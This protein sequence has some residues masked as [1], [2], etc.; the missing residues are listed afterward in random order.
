MLISSKSALADQVYPV[1][2]DPKNYCDKEKLVD[3]FHNPQISIVDQIESQV[4]DLIKSSHPTKALSKKELDR[5]IEEFFEGQIKEDYGNW[6]YYPWKYTLVHLLPE[7]EFIKV[8]TLRNNYKITPQE[9]AELAQKKVGIVGLSVGQSIALVMSLERSFG[10]LRLAD[11]DTLELS[12]LNRL[13]AG[14]TNLG[15]EKVVIAAR[16]ISEMDPYLK[17][18]LYRGG[19]SEDN[20]DEFFE[21]G[22]MLDLIIDECDSLDIKVLLREKARSKKVALMME[23]SDRG[24]LD[25]ERFDDEPDRPLFHGYLGD[26][27]LK[28]LK[29]L[30]NKQKVPM[31]LKITGE[32]TLSTRMKAS[33]LEVTQSITSWPQL[34][35]S[36]FLGGASIGH[37]A[38]NFLLGEDIESG[39]YFV[40]L[41]ELIPSKKIKKV[42]QT[43]SEGLSQS[44]SDESIYDY[45]EGS[46]YKLLPE[47]LEHLVRLANL[48]PSGGNS[49]PWKWVFDK[50]GV[51]HLFEDK[52]LS[53]SLLDYKSSGSLLAFGAALENIRLA[54]A[55][56]GIQVEIEYKISE[57][58]QDYIAQVRFLSKSSESIS[59]PFGELSQGISLRCTNRKNGPKEE[60][61]SEVLEILKTIGTK[62]KEISIEVVSSN[63]DL[64]QLAGIIG[65][66]DRY[67]LLHEQGYQDFMNEIRWSDEEAKSTGDGI[68]I[69][70]LEMD[71]SSRA[72]MGLVRDPGTVEFFRKHDLGF[73]LSKISDDTIL[74][75]SAILMIESDSYDPISILKAGATLQRIWLKANILGISIQPVS[76]SL[77]IFHRVECE[78]NS[79]FSPEEKEGIKGLKKGLNEIFNKDLK[80][81]EIF[82]IRL[83][84]ADEPSMRSY[85]RDVWTSLIVL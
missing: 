27:N 83:N 2:L 78:E 45:K 62:E 68:D 44:W 59:V 34:A 18:K 1:I 29:N 42:E 22:G 13:R 17:L 79:G 19:I 57:F 30:T 11:F 5:L 31:V 4:A 70:T 63:E 43:P 47:E 26:L 50:N 8:R 75:S 80:K 32:D 55:D 82:M 14:V 46:T 72:A 33:L 20:I 40:D 69:A 38:R 12:N 37:V 54:S 7:E 77:F 61:K 64:K 76:A 67:R 81:K 71:P 24:M 16:E 15:T 66:M 10:E 25:V 9:Q 28:S 51:L 60:L 84:K 53:N 35:S 21:D 39:R 85:R 52:S 6:V 3:L 23:T 74:S 41:D 65:G 56:M 58:E 73:G 36:V 48:A 49:Q